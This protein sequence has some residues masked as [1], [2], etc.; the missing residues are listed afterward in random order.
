MPCAAGWCAEGP[1]PRPNPHRSP[2][3]TYSSLKLIPANGSP[4]P[5][6]EGGIP[7]DRERVRVLTELG[8]KELSIQNSS[9]VSNLEHVIEMIQN[10]C[11]E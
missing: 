6:R 1:D 3:I 5:G 10:A 2:V 9:I 11:I 8:F 4:F 7:Y